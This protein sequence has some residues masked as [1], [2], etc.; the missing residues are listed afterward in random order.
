MSKVGEYYKEEEEL[1]IKLIDKKPSKHEIRA[2]IVKKVDSGEW[3]R[4]IPEIMEECNKFN[5]PVSDVIKGKKEELS[6]M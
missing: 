5:R 4:Y 2:Y 3:D 1:G 6:Q